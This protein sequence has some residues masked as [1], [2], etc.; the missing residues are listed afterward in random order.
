M[1]DEA[2]VEWRAIDPNQSLA[3]EARLL[4]ADNT[5]SALRAAGVDR[6]SV[7]VAGTDNDTVNLGVTTLAR[8]INPDIFVL[9]RQNDAADRVLIDAARANL[10]FVQ[11]ELIVRESLQ[12]LKTPL[13]GE[14]INRIRTGGSSQ[15]SRMIE[16]IMRTVGNMSPRNWEFHCDPLQPGLFGAFFH[17]SGEPLQIRHLLIDPSNREQSLEA[18]A[19]MHVRKNQTVMMPD[20][21]EA[22][23]PGDRLLFIGR[24]SARLRQT[25]LLTEPD[26]FDYI[27]FGI[28]QPRGWLFR[29]IDAKARSA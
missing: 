29:R 12:I 13:F 11:A 26:V 2:H 5:E 28:Q 17:A 3:R 9:I 24:E 27:R 14:F 19:I 8:R 20:P 4:A 25:R 22:L 6:A 21:N 23:R 15:A 7:L 18:A 10:R 1:L 16:L